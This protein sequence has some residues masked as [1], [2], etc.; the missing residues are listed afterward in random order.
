MNPTPWRTIGACTALTLSL[1]LAG[2]GDDESGVR[3][4][5]A[6]AGGPVTIRHAA[7]TTKLDRPAVRV[8]SLEWEFTEELL[9]IGVVPVGATDIEQ[10]RK[11]VGVRSEAL[12]KTRDLGTRQE[13]NLEAIASLRPD[14]IVGD[15]ERHKSIYSKLS[16]IAPTTL[17]SQYK[18]KAS[19]PEE[20]LARMS[21]TVRDLGKATGHDAQSETVLTH[22]DR[23]FAEA[24]KRIQT[25]GKAGTPYLLAQGF[26]D[27]GAPL[28]W[29]FLGDSWPGGVAAKVGLKP[30]YTG[31][32]DR[33]GFNQVGVEGLAK[34]PAG[35]AFFYQVQ[36]DDDVIA[37][38]IS[39]N[40]AWAS[41]PFVKDGAVHKLRPDTWFYGG[42]LSAERLAAQ[43]A[44][45]LAR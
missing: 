26:T 16:Q 19:D 1:A 33:Y 11:Y 27:Q 36:P 17:H 12:A 37:G 31:T 2:C 18:D 15:L 35:T 4:G 44:D 5:A 3:P 29:I 40:A 9:A 14:L 39:A 32:F 6:A 38:K 7:G 34:A 23:T 24:A 28:L 43:V 45:G 30:G 13:P 42:P 22:M 25:A 21:R 20:P 41:L 8:A 10:Y